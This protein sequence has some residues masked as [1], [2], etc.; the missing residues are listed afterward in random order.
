MISKCSVASLGVV[1]GGLTVACNGGTAET[2]TEEGSS[3]TGT[4]EDGGTTGGPTTDTPTTGDPTTGPTPS[5][6]GNGM[7]EEASSVTT[8]PTTPTTRRVR[9]PALPTSVATA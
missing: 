2:T 9:P 7:Q 5:V 6:C 1:A 3:G 4:T 8:G